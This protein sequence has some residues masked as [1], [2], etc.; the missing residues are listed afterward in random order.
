MAGASADDSGFRAGAESERATF[1]SAILGAPPPAARMHR[2]EPGASST[3]EK[4]RTETPDWDNSRASSSTAQ[5]AGA[6]VAILSAGSTIRETPAALSRNTSLHAPAAAAANAPSWRKDLL[7]KP[8]SCK[9]SSP[10]LETRK[11]K[12]KSQ[13]EGKS[14][15]GA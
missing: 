2:S 3:D 8:A 14:Q 7:D 10:D 11:D 9:R 5:A 1:W 6:E 13:W 12:G 4:R 15:S